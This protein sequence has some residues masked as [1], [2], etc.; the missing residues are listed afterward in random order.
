[1]AA[2]HCGLLKGIEAGREG[3][4][5]EL[6]GSVRRAFRRKISGEGEGEM[7]EQRDR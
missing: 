2:H 5:A 7:A 4:V 6:R 1:M 3:V